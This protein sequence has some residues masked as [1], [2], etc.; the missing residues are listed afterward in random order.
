MT[1]IPDITLLWTD[2]ETTGLDYENDLI[3]EVAWQVTNY[4]GE[5]LSSPHSFITVDHEDTELLGKVLDRYLKAGTY[6]QE[7]H[8][9]NGL[10]NEVLFGGPSDSR[11]GFY[12]V[13]DEM[14]ETI[15]A[16]RGDSE[17]RIAGSSV[18]FDKRFLETAYGGELPI[19]YR[20]HDLSTFRPFLKWQ[21]MDLDDFNVSAPDTH[22]ALADVMRDRDQWRGLISIIKD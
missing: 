14:F 16:V 8:R 2:I 10:W 4:L 12:E 9:N 3:L 13:L 20:V 11:A 19:S 22:R 6:V 17:V 7:M 1:E 5:P 18:G 15:N 21:G